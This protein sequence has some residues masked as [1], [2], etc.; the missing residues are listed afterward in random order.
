MKHTEI[1]SLAPWVYDTV[2][3]KC[4]PTLKEGDHLWQCVCTP[5]FRPV[6]AR[7]WLC[8]EQ[9]QPRTNLAKRKN[10]IFKSLSVHAVPYKSTRVFMLEKGKIGM[11]SQG[12]E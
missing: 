11:Y 12:A 7:M 8:G 4:N 9:C 3:G 10:V 2:N 5:S 1:N 6:L